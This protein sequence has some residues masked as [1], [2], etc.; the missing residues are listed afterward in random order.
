[1]ES[2]SSAQQ[3]LKLIQCCDRSLQR[4]FLLSL[5]LPS[6]KVAVF[7]CRKT[8]P[9]Q[10]ELVCLFRIASQRLNKAPESSYSSTPTV[11]SSS[12][13]ALIE[14]FASVLGAL[15]ILELQ[16]YKVKNLLGVINQNNELRLNCPYRSHIDRDNNMSKLQLQK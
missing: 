4:A 7:L 6:Y 15:T 9:P 5:Q 1:M 2:I 11:S 16:K 13:W 10:C 3:F 12:S 8:N 14:A